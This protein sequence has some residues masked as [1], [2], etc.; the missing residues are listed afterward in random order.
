[1]L[2]TSGQEK[3]G[4]ISPTEIADNP[5]QAT[6][7]KARSVLQEAGRTTGRR[8]DLVFGSRLPVEEDLYL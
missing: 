1:M 6:S 4:T 8:P 7:M 2:R 5:R 3:G